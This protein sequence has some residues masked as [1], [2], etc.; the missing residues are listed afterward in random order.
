MKNEFCDS[1]CGKNANFEQRAALLHEMSPLRIFDSTR[2]L[3]PTLFI[4]GSEDKVVLPIES[5]TML[6]CL[7][8]AGCECYYLNVEGAKH[9]G[10]GMWSRAV[11]DVIL[12]FILGL[13]N[14]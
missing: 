1:F 3:K 13:T 11:Y 6:E 9:D 2:V 4:H 7:E 10:D 14:K 12:E 5:E 8:K